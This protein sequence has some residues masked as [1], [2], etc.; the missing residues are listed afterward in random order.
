MEQNLDSKIN[1]KEKIVLFFRYN[2]LKI[3]V[4]IN[5]INKKKN[6]DLLF[7]RNKSI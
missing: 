5:K 4:E 1:N 7:L 3:I 2:K 6:L